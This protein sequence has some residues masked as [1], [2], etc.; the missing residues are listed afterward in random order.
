MRRVMNFRFALIPVV[1][2]A[3]VLPARAQAPAACE[4]PSAVFSGQ[5]TMEGTIPQTA[6]RKL[7]DCVTEIDYAG[8]MDCVVRAATCSPQGV[9]PER[10]TA[11]VAL[12]FTQMTMTCA[13]G[14]VRTTEMYKGTYKFV[15][16]KGLPFSVCVVNGVVDSSGALSECMTAISSSSSPNVREAGSGMATG[17]RQ[18]KPLLLTMS[19][20]KDYVGHVTLMK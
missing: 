20:R 18:H 16:A 19:S 11:D 4:C 7:N 2:A 9:T 13:D 6:T 15:N 17:K 3:F 10:C 14:S 1:M 8:T 12:T 5:M